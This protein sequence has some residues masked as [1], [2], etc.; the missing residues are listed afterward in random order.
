MIRCDDLSE[1]KTFSMECPVRGITNINGK[2]H[3]IGEAQLRVLN[4]DFELIEGT[5]VDED[6]DDITTDLYGNIIYSCFKK[7]TI[8]KKDGKNKI[9][10]VYQHSGLKRPY[11]L[12]VDPKGNI[13]VCG[14]HSHNIFVISGDGSLLKILDGFFSPQ[15]IAFQEN[16]FKFFVV[17]NKSF[18]KICELK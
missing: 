13:Y 17:Q 3:V 15:F 5:D 2:F 16:S 10:F 14:H 12:A 6:S 18:V 8:T 7:N 9:Q 4:S 1:I 11:G